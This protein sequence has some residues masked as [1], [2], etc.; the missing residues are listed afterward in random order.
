MEQLSVTK[1]APAEP[2]TVSPPAVEALPTPALLL[3]LDA[4]EQN[5]AKMATFL[6]RKGV[7]LRP[8]AKTHKCPRIALKQMEAGAEGICV[9][10]LTEAEAFIAAGIRQVLVTT[11]VVDLLQIRRLMTLVKSAPDVTVV[12][13]NPAN[14]DALEEAAAAAGVRMPVLVDLDCGAHRTGVAPGPASTALAQRV[15]RARALR[16]GGFQAYAAHLMHVV[17]YDDRRR[18]ELEALDYALT[19]RRLAERAG[20]PVSVF[21]V[22][23]TGTYD[24]DCD[25]DGVTDV[26]AGS[27]V[28]MDVM[29]RAIGG[30]ASSVYDDFK[31]ALFVLSTAVSQPVQGFITIDAGYKAA[32]A[33][34]QPP[35]PWNLGDVSYQ[36]AGDE[37][38][39][40]TLTNPR[41]EVRVGDKIRLIVSHCDPTVNLYDR[42]H[43]CRGDQ[44]VDVWPIVARGAL[45]V[46]AA[47]GGDV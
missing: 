43:V 6:R 30:R 32:A 22:G 20:L 41:R 17:G 19:A 46:T 13:D 23:G 21:S 15:A 35:Q 28:F 8:H 27:Y 2:A 24:V 47:P 16:F 9:A 44:V 34:H 11:P 14:V 37:H 31:P 38:G 33:D 10:K 42:F 12:V 39:I 7:A 1:L 3:D 18:S 40:L 29:Y 45:P 36:W 5:L 4:F 26:Q 25:I